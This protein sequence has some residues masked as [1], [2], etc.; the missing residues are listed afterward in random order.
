[1]AKWKVLAGGSS[2]S[3]KVVSTKSRTG[4]ETVIKLSKS[5]HTYE[6]Q[7]LDSHGNV[8]AHGTSKT[9]S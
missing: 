7:A 4:F 1:M 9:F 3:L 6:L 5:F 2:S 8:L